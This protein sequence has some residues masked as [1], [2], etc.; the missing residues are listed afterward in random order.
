MNCSEAQEL[1]SRYHDNELADAVRV[2]VEEHLGTCDA[3]VHDIAAFRGMTSL[4]QQLPDPE[5]PPE[6]WGQLEEQFPA[7]RLTQAPS[8]VRHVLGLNRLAVAAILLLA[9]GLGVSFVLHVRHDHMAGDA[10]DFG[11]YMAAFQSG[12]EEAQRVL[13]ARHTG[14]RLG[15]AEIERKTQY[16]PLVADGAPPGFHVDAT[17]LIDMPCCMCV[18]TIC[19]ADNGQTLVLFEHA[20]D[21]CVCFGK[22]TGMNCQCAG[23]QTQIVAQGEYLAATWP[24]GKR[25]VTLIGARDVEQ[26]VQVMYHFDRPKL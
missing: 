15:L 18:Q 14:Q 7:R 16:R 13:L 22:D 11:P 24:A 8:F 17:Y 25:S 21:Q 3:C 12:P 6:L 19:K 23:K 1:L 26:V 9:A 2:S 5:P 4:A 10:M 20:K